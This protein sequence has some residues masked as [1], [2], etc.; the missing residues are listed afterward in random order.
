MSL[1]SSASL[2]NN[3]ESQHKKKTSS[4]K[5][6]KKTNTLE[7]FSPNDYLQLEPP[8]SFD[9][10][11]KKINDL[12]NKMTDVHASN[13]DELANFTPLSPP[14][15]TTKK[16][17]FSPDQLM[18]SY[19]KENIQHSLLESLKAN[20]SHLGKLSDYNTSYGRTLTN[21]TP[22][23]SKPTIPSADNNLIEKI[24]YM[25]HLLEEQHREP[26]QNVKEEFV[27][28]TFLG[29][30]MIFVVDSFS[31]ASKYVR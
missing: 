2:W 31:K 13:E 5:T 3:D 20:D 19:S 7:N 9:L 16:P 14:E 26:T 15:I 25:I 4:R 27:L 28:Y 1:L 10:R 29:V 23:Y 12:L 18:P 8:S 24:N 6:I 30:F 22:F 11:Q 17:D 21:S